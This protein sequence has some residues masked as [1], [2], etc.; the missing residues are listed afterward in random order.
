LRLTQ[1]IILLQ[2]GANMAG[3]VFVVSALQILYI[4]TVLLP[5][6]LRP[7]LW[8]RLALI[9]MAVFYGCFF[10]VW[11]M[12]GILPDPA[13]GFIFNIPKYFLGG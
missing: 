13:K 6:E 7:S 9:L 10:Y 5:V 3:L 8:R 2:L 1:P 11:L 4:N 12:G